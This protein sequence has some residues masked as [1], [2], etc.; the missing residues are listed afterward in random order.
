MYYHIRIDI[1]D[2]DLKENRT[3]Y[4]FDYQSEDDLLN[5]VYK[6]YVKGDKFMFQGSF[7]SSKEIK[8]IQVYQ[9]KDKIDNMKQLINRNS[10][11]GLYSI[12]DVLTL[13]EHSVDIT[14]DIQNKTYSA[15]S[16]IKESD[17]SKVNV[18]KKPMVFISHNSEDIDFVEALIDMLEGIGLDKSN[19]FCSSIPNLWIDINDNIYDALRDMFE[20]YDMYVLFILSPRFYN[21]VASLNE[22]GAAWVL[23]SQYSSF[24]TSDMQFDNVKGVVDPR[25]LAIAIKDENVSF[26]LNELKDHILSFLNLPG[27]DNSKW[28]RYRNRFIKAVQ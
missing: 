9:T 3:L 18:T 20:T 22:M 28:E 7:L 16:Y 19:L 12:Y 11:Y 15:I 8:Q 10:S 4:E 2:K 17:M 27:V 23:H 24:L 14:R 26:R 13:R 25:R 6:P 1:Y 5:E 21:S